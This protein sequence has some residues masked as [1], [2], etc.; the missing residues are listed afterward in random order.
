MPDSRLRQWFGGSLN[1]VPLAGIQYGHQSPERHEPIF[2][3]DPPFSCPRRLFR[4]AS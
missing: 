3:P 1:M 2:E 4:L